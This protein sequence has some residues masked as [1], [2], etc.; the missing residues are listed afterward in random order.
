MI[1][2]KAHAQFPQGAAI[3]L[4]KSLYFFGDPRA[5]KNAQFFCELKCDAARRPLQ[6]FAFFKLLKRTEEFFHMLRQP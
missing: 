4:R 6:S 3:I 1:S 5:I 2:A